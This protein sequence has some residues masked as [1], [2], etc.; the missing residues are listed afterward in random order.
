MRSTVSAVSTSSEGTPGSEVFAAVRGD[1]DGAHPLGDGVG[2]LAS[3][4]DHLVQHQVGVAEVLADDVPVQLL[5]DEMQVD[6]VDVDLLQVV[7]ELLGR[8][9]RRAGLVDCA[10][11]RGERAGHLGTFLCGDASDART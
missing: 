9:E 4:L 2:E 5:A 8:P 1:V 7:G 10:I 3:R 11:G 6:Q